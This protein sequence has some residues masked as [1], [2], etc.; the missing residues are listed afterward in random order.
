MSRSVPG[1]CTA[2]SI[3]IYQLQASC[4]DER[5]TGKQVGHFIPV[6]EPCCRL[7]F[8][9][10]QLLGAG[11]SMLYRPVFMPLGPADS[12]TTKPK[13]YERELAWGRPRSAAGWRHYKQVI[14]R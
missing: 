3:P 8:I 11:E 2:L 6:P 1:T 7:I 14:D 12:E 13:P 4:T 9:C 10:D 5:L